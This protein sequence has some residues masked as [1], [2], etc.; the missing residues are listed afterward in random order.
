MD[1]F[2][3]PEILYAETPDFTR[4]RG[5]TSKRFRVLPCICSIETPAISYAEASGFASQ[6]FG[7]VAL[8]VISRFAQPFSHFV[9]HSAATVIQTYFRGYRALSQYDK[10]VASIIYCQSIIRRFQAVG[11]VAIKRKERDD[12]IWH[13]KAAATQIQTCFRRHSAFS[14]KAS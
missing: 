11:E 1:E 7:W 14:G 13:T 3:A 8:L 6:K 4:K 10:D 2:E 5:F 12:D 9:S